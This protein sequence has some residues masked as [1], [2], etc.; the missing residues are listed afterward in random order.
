MDIQPYLKESPVVVALRN[1]DTDSSCPLL[2]DAIG[3]GVWQQALDTSN[4]ACN[5]NYLYQSPFAAEVSN[6]N[7]WVELP[8]STENGTQTSVTYAEFQTQVQV[9]QVGLAPFQN[10]T[11]R[12]DAPLATIERDFR[13]DYIIKI[14]TSFTATSQVRACFMWL[15]NVCVLTLKTKPFSVFEANKTLSHGPTAVNDTATTPQTQDVAIPVLGNDILGYSSEIDFFANGSSTNQTGPN[16][17]LSLTVVTQPAHG[18]VVASLE[19]R[20][21]TYTPNGLFYGSDSFTYAITDVVGSSTATVFVRVTPVPPTARADYATCLENDKVDINVLL[22]DLPGAGG[23]KTVTVSAPP[24]PSQGSAVVT[25]TNHILFTPA[26]NWA[27]DVSFRYTVCDASTLVD[28]PLCDS[29]QVTVRITTVMP[30]CNALEI[31]LNE[32]GFP[33]PHALDVLSRVNSGSARMDN[34]SLLI[35]S[36]PSLGFAVANTTDATVVYTLKRGW[37]GIDTIGYRL[38]DL[39]APS[40]QCCSSTITVHVRAVPPIAHP[41][42]VRF[43]FGGP[44]MTFNPLSVN[45]PGALPLD[46]TKLTWSASASGMFFLFLFLCLPQ[47]LRSTRRYRHLPQPSRQWR[48]QLP[49]YSCWH[50]GLASGRPRRPCHWLAH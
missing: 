22:N 42:T 5:S 25:A 11:A 21:I 4:G 13:R 17:L 26:E 27:S 46:P 47:P 31:S 20:N 36:Q 50:Y 10:T 34:S 24:S 28:G 14:A 30:Q 41:F 39:T 15:F 33:S 2:S 6:A 3:R 18:T 16:A 40:P 45:E 9:L 38:C 29:A 48:F 12:T 43:T 1:P 32:T 49:T 8:S 35:I 44:P 37:Y 23:F 7:C 19:Y